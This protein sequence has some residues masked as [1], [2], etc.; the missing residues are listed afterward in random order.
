MNNAPFS[1]GQKVLCIK[2]ISDYPSYCEMFKI[3]V[4][5]VYTVSACEPHRYISSKWAIG[6][7][8]PY[9]KSDRYLHTQFAPIEAAYS[10]ATAEIL[11][12]FK[13]TTEVPDK[14]LIPETA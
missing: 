13:Q 10:D 5:E 6:L 3:V 14:I 4:G 2:S 11:E 9:D 1:I 12:K 7:E 8:E